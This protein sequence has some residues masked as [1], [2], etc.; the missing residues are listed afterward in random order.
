ML[1]PLTRLV[2]R[3]A[4][5]AHKVDYLFS[6]AVSL[7]ISLLVSILDLESL[8]AEVYFIFIYNK[9]RQLQRVD[10]ALLLRAALISPRCL[11]IVVR[12]GTLE[13][14]V[15]LA[16]AHRHG[17]IRLAAILLDVVLKALLVA[18]ATI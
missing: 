18:L 6:L 9:L 17:H 14:D 16:R 4:T 15:V 2:G 10:A 12:C 8:V 13:L 3:C 7:A 1:L 11:R 5:G